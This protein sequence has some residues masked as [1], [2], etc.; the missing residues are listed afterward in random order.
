[1]QAGASLPTSETI[2]FASSLK[3]FLYS[4]WQILRKEER[5]LVVTRL[6]F[7]FSIVYTVH[8]F[9]VFYSVYTLVVYTWCLLKEHRHE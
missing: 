4:N 2:E 9:L 1:M 7:T 8:T 3:L 6:L 5:C